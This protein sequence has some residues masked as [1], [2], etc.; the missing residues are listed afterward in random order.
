MDSVARPKALPLTVNLLRTI[1]NFVL[2]LSPHRASAKVLSAGTGHTC[3]RNATGAAICWGNRMQSTVP[4]SVAGVVDVSAGG[5]H[6][7]AVLLDGTATC[8]GDN[9]YGQS[10]IPTG[11]ANV[12]EIVAGGQHTCFLSTDGRVGCFGN[13]ASGQADPP[14]GLQIA[15]GV[16][17]GRQHSCAW[18]T[19]GTLT[20]WGDDTYNQCSGLSVLHGLN[21]ISASL[22]DLHTCGLLSNRSVVCFGDNSTGQ[23]AV[24]GALNATIISCGGYH[25]CAIMTISSGVR[26][27]GDNS[28]GQSAVPVTAGSGVTAVAA[29]AA[30]T[31]LW[32]SVNANVT[33]FGDNG[34][35]QALP[36][37]Q[38]VG[39]IGMSFEQNTGGCIWRSD[40]S[41]YCWGLHFALPANATSAKMVSIMGGTVATLRPDGF[42]VMSGANNYG[43]NYPP[44]QVTSGSVSGVAAG[45]TGV[46]A[47]LTNGSGYCWGLVLFNPISNVVSMSNSVYET[48][49]C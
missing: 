4:V 46:C 6:S 38:L 12:A 11:T 5:G 25:C 7:C 35:W 29:G 3:V 19:N 18:L 42:L 39:M 40:H 22:G 49:P 32:S 1:L 13:S 44:S 36:P 15:T 26:C 47:W 34:Y 41:V 23:L 10:A 14:A 27:W 43:V 9:T 2:L 48:A 16:A 30:H 33:C 20:C 8:W 37:G 21:V 28:A 24:P 17:V 31:C 45:G